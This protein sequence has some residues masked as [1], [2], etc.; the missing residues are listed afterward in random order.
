LTSATNTLGISGTKPAPAGAA[1]FFLT[2]LDQ[3]LLS[4]LMLSVNLALIHWGTKAE[5]ALFAIVMSAILLSQSIQN[6]AICVPLMVLGRLW[7]P[8]EFPGFEAHL[9]RMNLAGATISAAACAGLALASTG[10]NHSLNLGLAGAAGLAVAGVWL[11]EYRRTTQ[12]REDQL[13][14]LAASDAVVAALVLS[15]LWF[16]IRRGTSLSAIGVLAALGSA[17][18]LVSIRGA[19]PERHAPAASQQVLKDWWAQIR[20]STA[21]SAVSWLQATSYPILAAAAA[22]T[23]AAADVA[24]ARLFLSPGLLL[25]TAWGRLGILGAAEAIHAGGLGRWRRF[26]SDQTVR[27][28][29]G[30]VGYIVIVVIAVF[31]GVG[32]ILGDEYRNTALIWCW[33]LVGLLTTI[34]GVPTVSLQGAAAFGPLMRW[35]IVSAV[36]SCTA[37]LAF[38]KVWGAAGCVLGV[39]A[40]ELINGVAFFTVVRRLRA[41]AS[42]SAT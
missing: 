20:M 12:L 34:R 5:Y 13:G 18:L 37:V 24:A 41:P 14:A 28:G 19:L 4:V 11:R 2:A 7:E 27:V 40:G 21:W 8:R 39:A 36:G 42:S 32:R 17:N 26:V 6:A 22:G 38:G 23:Q 15:A 1:R 9:R 25:L 31:L 10:G 3:G 16:L 33:L 29:L 30:S 35:G